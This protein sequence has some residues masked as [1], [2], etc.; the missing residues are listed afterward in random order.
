MREKR[1]SKKEEQGEKKL[2][3]E[4]GSIYS[5]LGNG[6]ISKKQ[7]KK[8]IGKISKKKIVVSASFPRL[9]PKSNER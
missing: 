3:E 9:I 6:V 4:R 7:K 8:K 1:A 5:R 2:F